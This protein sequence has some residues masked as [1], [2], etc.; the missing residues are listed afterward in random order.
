MRPRPMCFA[1]VLLATVAA[2]ASTGP[3]LQIPL[4]IP[5]TFG[6]PVSV[7]ILF[8]SNGAAISA[9]VFSVDYD[10]ACLDFDSA[11]A[12]LDG[13]PDDI[14]F[15][16]PSQFTG[17]VTFEP[18][19]TDGELDFVVADFGPPITSL[20]DSVLA[21]MIFTPT[22]QA[23]QAPVRFSPDP[24]PSFGGTGGQGVPGKS[25]DGSVA[26][27]EQIFADGF[28]SGDLSAWSND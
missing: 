23:G 1:I 21:F 6:L 18:N 2:N 10:E 14:V 15:T 16:L 11:D 20:T 7:P 4:A 24:P 9:I 12:D 28:E 17:S 5:G 25:I 22:C 13:I 3:V 26:I 8:I 27:G 19:D